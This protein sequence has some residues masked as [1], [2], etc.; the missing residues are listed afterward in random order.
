[1]INAEGAR[2]IAKKKQQKNEA[3]RARVKKSRQA[4]RARAGAFAVH[5]RIQARASS[6]RKFLLC[7]SNKATRK[8]LKTDGFGVIVLGPI[9]LIRW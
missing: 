4:T 2:S 6:G 1:M 5:T 3:A 9:T 7:R 8:Q